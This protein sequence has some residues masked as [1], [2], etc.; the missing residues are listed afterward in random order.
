LTE[1]TTD[2]LLVEAF[3]LAMKGKDKEAHNFIEKSLVIQYCL[4]LGRDGVML[5]FKRCV[6]LLSRQRELFQQTKYSF[7]C[8]IYRM[9][10]S[11]PKALKVFLDDLKVTSKR[12]IDRAHTVAAEK[13]DTKEEEGVEQIQLVATDPGITITFEVPDG[14]PPE[15]IEITGEG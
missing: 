10:A 15:K 13:K 3:S 7:N 1:E 6:L 4:R 9:T 12:I 2:A 14:P 8:G 11:D 5:Y